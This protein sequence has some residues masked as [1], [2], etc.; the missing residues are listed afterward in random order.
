[1][2][3]QKREQTASAN[4]DSVAVS[5]TATLEQPARSDVLVTANGDAVYVP[6]P[7]EQARA[8]RPKADPNETKF[9]KFR[10]LAVRRMNK[11]LKAVRDLIPLANRSAYEYGQSEV[12][13]IKRALEEAVRDV[14]LAFANVKAEKPGFTLL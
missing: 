2:A 5:E 11:A 8:A 14:G 3:K 4:D 6:T 12:D 7:L 1:M 10:R 13:Q 9:A